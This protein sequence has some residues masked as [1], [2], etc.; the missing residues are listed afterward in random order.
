MELPEPM[1][2][3]QQLQI[4]EDFAT[5]LS[6]QGMGLEQYLQ[7]TGNTEEKMME[8]VRPQALDRIK[9]RLVLEAVADAE[10]LTA[11]DEEVEKEIEDRAKQN[12][13]AVDIAVRKAAD[14]LVDNAKDGKAK[15]S[16]GKKKA[17]AEE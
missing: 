16:R 12:F 13:I 11:S 4:L 3:S 17:D 5:R 10:G 14:F 6:Y 9:S 2:E 7:M 15:K 8:Q 1:I